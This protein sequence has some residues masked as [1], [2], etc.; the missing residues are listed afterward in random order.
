MGSFPI[1]IFTRRSSIF[2]IFHHT[3]AQTC[4]QYS[5]SQAPQEPNIHICSPTSSNHARCWNGRQVC[6]YSFS[7]RPVGASAHVSLSP[8]QVLYCIVLIK[9]YQQSIFTSLF[10]FKK[11]LDKLIIHHNSPPNRRGRI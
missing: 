10:I 3:H 7:A 6:S 2:N 4:A 11:Y 1:T 8:I 9:L 5:C